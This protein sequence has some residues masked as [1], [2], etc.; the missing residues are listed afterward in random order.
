M[1]T[2]DQRYND[3][4]PNGVLGEANRLDDSQK[5]AVTAYIKTLEQNRA[6]QEEN[7][8]KVTDFLNENYDGLIE[9]EEEFSNQIE[10]LNSQLENLKLQETQIRRNTNISRT[11]R[12]EQLRIIEARQRETE[13]R[14]RRLTGENSVEYD[15]VVNALGGSNTSVGRLL[16]NAENDSKLHESVDKIIPHLGQN[17]SALNKLTAIVGTIS[18]GLKELKADMTKSI[19]NAASFLEGLY[20]PLKAN[21][22]GSE[23]SY[24]KISDDVSETLGF[25]RLV[26]QTS[27]LSKISELS[28][29]GLMTDLEQRALLATIKDKT[30][31]SFDVSNESL[32][33]LIRLGE[34]N[35]VNQFGVELQLKRLLNSKLFGDSS[36]LKGMFD[37]VSG[38]ILEA[39]VVGKS[40]ITNFNS[41]VQTWLGAMYASG[42]SDSVISSI[43]SGINALGSGNVNALSSDENIQR[44]FLLS[45]DRVGMDYAD[46]LQ[47]GLSSSDTN[48]LL[49]AVVEYLNEI[50]TNT[51]DN[52]V[53]KSSYSNLF[54]LSVA[55]M[56]AI[57]NVYSKVG[58]ISSSI[59]GASEAQSITTNAV[60]QMV[61]Q[62]TL[63]SEKF[64]NFFSN[65]SY[66]FGSNIAESGT[67][68]TTYRIA[69]IAYNI[70][71]KFSGVGGTLGKV[72]DVAKIV[73]AA[74]Q[75]GIG[76][77]SFVNMLTDS[78]GSGG[79]E[80]LLSL[81]NATGGGA[82]STGGSS[83]FKTFKSKA[84]S[85][86]EA[87]IKSSQEDWSKVEEDESVT[88]LKNI[89]KAL[90][91]LKEGDGYAFAVSVEGMND[92]VLRSFA[93]IFADEDA[94]LSTFTGDNK[95]LKDALFDYVN[96]TTSNTKK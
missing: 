61:A 16:D 49:S 10:L 57:H 18:A 43:A 83:S 86:I 96:D 75:Y 34:Q 40:D 87:A 82:S 3:R 68:Y 59:I 2:I 39:S 67:L 56:E 53:L 26:K 33:R 17:L 65:F 85:D 70:L 55:D 80:S 88:M 90:M 8:K 12:E 25:S 44:L 84:T 51:S 89:T 91:K 9:N 19:N 1:A 29:E 79:S 31:T 23:Y 63:A 14:K 72:I 46:I 62:N 21:L 50:A 71:D 30:L 13:N 54:N 48:K 36:Y 60:S 77:I 47:Q 27:Y 69:D 28:A 5:E 20:G 37:S 95:V 4:S 45:M 35:S 92:T 52:L 81:L 7:I 15:A 6:V 32:K 41:T 58:A 78:W 93:S 42:L 66:S 73:P 24:E 74:V 64:D 11:D 22:E 94:M 38:A 76:G